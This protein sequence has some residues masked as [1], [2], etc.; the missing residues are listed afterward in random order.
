L[1]KLKNLNEPALIVEIT[2]KNGLIPTKF[3]AFF[4]ETNLII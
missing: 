1:D 2:N 4:K 3:L